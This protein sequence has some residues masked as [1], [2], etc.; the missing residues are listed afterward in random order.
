MDPVELPGI[1]AVVAEAAD[2]AAVLALDDADLVVLAVGAEQI[3]LL[4]IGP[5]REVPHRAVAER[6]LLEEPLLDEGAVLLEHLDAVVDAVADIDQPVIGDLHAMHGIAELLRDRR[7]GIVGG[8]LGRRRARCRRRPSAA[9]RR[10]VVA[11]NTMTRRL[12]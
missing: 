3:G 10:R 8:L 9:C 4:R 5:D 1:A 7:L 6:V 2:H 12:P 11:S